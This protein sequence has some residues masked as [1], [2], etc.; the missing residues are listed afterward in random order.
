MSI[1]LNL[2][3]KSEDQAIPFSSIAT[4]FL[5]EPPV[6]SFLYNLKVSL[7]NDLATRPQGIAGPASSSLVYPGLGYRVSGLK[8]NAGGTSAA[9]LSNYST[10]YC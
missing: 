10:E 5:A 3:C 4:W 7:K 9:A 6:E 1:F 8:G 2:Y